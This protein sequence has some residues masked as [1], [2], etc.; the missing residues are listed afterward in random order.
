MTGIALSAVY[1][2]KNETFY[3]PEDIRSLVDGHKN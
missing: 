3:L 2:G 1:V